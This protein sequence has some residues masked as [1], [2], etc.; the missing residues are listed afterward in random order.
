MEKREEEGR[1]AG[2]SSALGQGELTADKRGI[3]TDEAVCMRGS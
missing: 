1:E 2:V 3:W